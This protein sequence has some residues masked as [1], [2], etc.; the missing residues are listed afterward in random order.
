MI[1]VLL[2]TT[3]IYTLVPFAVAVTLI[4]GL[5]P[6]VAA[7]IAMRNPRTA[8]RLALWFTPFAALFSFRLPLYSPD[9]YLPPSLIVALAVSLMPGL[10]WLMAGRRNWPLPVSSTMLPRRSV[11]NLAAIGGLACVFLVTSIVVSLMLPWWP[12]IG[13]CSAGQLLDESGKPRFVDFTAKIVAVGPKSLYG[14]SLF[15]IARVEDRFSDSIWAVPKFV[16]LRDFFRSTDRGEEFFIEGRRS[17]GPLTSFLPVVERVE[18]GHSNRVSEAVV[19][20]RTLRE[21]PPQ[22][23]VR[24]IGAVFTSGVA[25]PK[26]SVPAPGIQ[27]LIKG[28]AGNIVV[29]TDDRGVYEAAGLPFGHYTVEL[30][31]T[32]PHPLCALNLE[33]HPV[34]GCSLFL[35]EVRQPNGDS[36]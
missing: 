33:K 20:L 21:G 12:R 15:S 36:L 23:G 11:L 28:P 3:Q 2:G 17:F 14:Y 16:I 6:V 22:T 25:Q 26:A 13:D 30:S 34:D 5:L 24:I 31:T 19:A 9:P 10:F 29:T 32:N 27:V 18:C 7:C 35:D 4:F 8:S 1:L